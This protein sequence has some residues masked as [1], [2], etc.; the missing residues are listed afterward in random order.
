[1]YFDYLSVLS[2]QYCMPEAGVD[3]SP[4]KQLLSTK[5]II[6]LARLFVA[7]GVTKIRL[8]GGE[9]LVRSDL[10]DIISKSYCN[11]LD[12]QVMPISLNPVWYCV[13]MWYI[14]VYCTMLICR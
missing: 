6:K 8:T 14:H 2:G 10:A 4:K 11:I 13:L 7:E 9:P 3:L 5:E 12:Y 1:M